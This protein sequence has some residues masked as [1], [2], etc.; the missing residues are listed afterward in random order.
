M[1]EDLTAFTPFVARVTGIVFLVIVA[2]IVGA[3]LW[4]YR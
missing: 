3:I 1:S 4:I 2:A